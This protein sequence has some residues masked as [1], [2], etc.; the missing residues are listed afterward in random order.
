MSQVSPTQTFIPM[1]RTGKIL[2]WG[3][4]NDDIR[5]QAFDKLQRRNSSQVELMNRMFEISLVDF[6]GWLPA[7]KGSQDI[8]ASVQKA[9]GQATAATKQIYSE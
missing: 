4:A 8:D 9:L 5:L 3:T 2:A 7:I 6:D 1:T